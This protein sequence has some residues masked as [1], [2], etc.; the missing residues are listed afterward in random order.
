DGLQAL[1]QSLA[2]A[3]DVPAVVDVTPETAQALA[4][5]SD[6]SAQAV[7]AD[8]RRATDR[9]EVVA[10]AFVPIDVPAVLSTGLDG[11]GEAEV[12]RGRDALQAIRLRPSTRTFV[13]DGPL[14]EASL[15]W[16]GSVG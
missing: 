5:S 1:T 11:E 10:S 16:L 7:L 12:A 8:L 2:A 14:D 15:S 4:T 9:R 6:P 3:P 13:T